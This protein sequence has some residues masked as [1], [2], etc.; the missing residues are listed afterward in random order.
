M[1]GVLIYGFLLVLLR[2]TGKRQVGEM[3]P[4][5]LVLLLVLSNAVQNAM[6]AGDNSVTAGLLLATI[7]VGLNFCAGL[8][9]YRS[10]RWETLLEGR[11]AIVIRD[12]HV[13]EYVMKHEQITREELLAAL[14]EHGCRSPE[15]V[16]LGVL[17]TNGRISIIPR[18]NE[19]VDK[20]G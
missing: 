18:R 4:F 5:D 1:R 10:R 6:N 14:R 11:A 16:R 17:E 8:L 13:L 20:K 15:E 3:A 9:T 2:L 19:D 7:L 12:G